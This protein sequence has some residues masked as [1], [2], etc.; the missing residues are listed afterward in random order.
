MIKL[1]PKMATTEAFGGYFCRVMLRASLS[2][3]DPKE[4]SSRNNLCLYWPVMPIKASVLVTGGGFHLPVSA[5]DF[6]A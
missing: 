6:G 5:S 2:E 4:T 1:L 3:S